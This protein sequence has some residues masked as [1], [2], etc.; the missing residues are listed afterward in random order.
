MDEQAN[1]K[2]KWQ[3]PTVIEID[4]NETA[5]CAYGNVDGGACS[6][7]RLAGGGCNPGSG[8]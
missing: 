4:V 1:D 2:P 3:E 5:L 6:D 8:G 7:G